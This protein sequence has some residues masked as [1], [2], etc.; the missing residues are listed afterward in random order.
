MNASQIS[1]WFFLLS[2]VTDSNPVLNQANLIAASIFD[3]S[4]FEQ[5]TMILIHQCWRHA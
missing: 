4:Y 1:T 5:V 2:S 3:F